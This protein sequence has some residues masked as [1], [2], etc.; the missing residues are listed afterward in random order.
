MSCWLVPD[1]DVQKN[2]Q[3]AQARTEDAGV[4]LEVRAEKSPPDA[5]CTPPAV[6][7]LHV[8][9]FP[10]NRRTKLPMRQAREEL[11]MTAQTLAS[12]RPLKTH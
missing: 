4:L 11:R 5:H 8:N 12:N 2:R 3:K 6:L 1:S 9:T 7:P 10:V